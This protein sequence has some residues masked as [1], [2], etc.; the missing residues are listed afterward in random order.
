MVDEISEK[1]ENVERKERERISI[2]L[3]LDILEFFRER[4]KQPDTSPYQRQINNELRQ[5]VDAHKRANESGLSAIEN[6]IL[7]NE[8]F[9]KKLKEKMEKI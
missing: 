9:V 1:D 8:T 3:D 2:F 7:E 5:I 4:A 6:S